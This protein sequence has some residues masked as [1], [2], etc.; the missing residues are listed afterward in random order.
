VVAGHCLVAYDDGTVLMIGGMLPNQNAETRKT[1]FYDNKWSP[2]P[3]LI[4]ERSEHSCALFKSAKHGNTETVI[5]AGGV[6]KI[7]GDLTSTEF[8]RFDSNSWTPGTGCPIT[9]GII[10]TRWGGHF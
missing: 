3:E 1:F 8:L 10:I 9:H 4:T 2:G 7:T 6:N 5:V